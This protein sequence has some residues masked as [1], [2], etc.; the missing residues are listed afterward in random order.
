MG[1]NKK[2]SRKDDLKKARSLHK[3]YLE[4]Q[5]KIR[6]S[7]DSLSIPHWRTEKKTFLS[8]I[9]FYFSRAKVRYNGIDN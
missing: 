9:K 8:R 4:H 7:P 1:K 5:E 6:D 3:Q 2:P